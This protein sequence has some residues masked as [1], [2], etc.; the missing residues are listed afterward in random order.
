[1]C[2]RFRQQSAQ[3]RSVIFYHLCNRFLRPDAETALSSLIRD[4]TTIA[5]GQTAMTLFSIAARLRR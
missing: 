2:C 1:M 5:I 3:N 4:G